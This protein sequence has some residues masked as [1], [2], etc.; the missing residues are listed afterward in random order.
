MEAREQEDGW[1]EGRREPRA[2][3]VHLTRTLVGAVTLDAQDYGIVDAEEAQKRVLDALGD[4]M[5]VDWENY[6]DKVDVAYPVGAL[7]VPRSW[8]GWCEL[9]DAGFIGG[10]KSCWTRQDEVGARWRERV[11]KRRRAADREWRQAHH[12]TLWDTGAESRSLDAWKCGDCDAKGADRDS[13]KAHE[14]TPR[15]AA[16]GG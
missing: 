13:R 3:T 1:A 12:Q 2:W 14:Q 5:K 4:G 9:H 8:G 15:A 11:E 7:C 6:G 16:A 10:A